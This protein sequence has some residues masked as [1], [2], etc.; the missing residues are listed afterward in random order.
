MEAGS[1]TAGQERGARDTAPKRGCANSNLGGTAEYIIRPNVGWVFFFYQTTKQEEAMI[2]SVKGQ[3]KEFEPGVSALDVFK[4]LDKEARK[5]AIAARLD[6]EFLELMAPITKGGE[7][8]PVGFEDSEARHLL[9]HTASH[10]MASAVKKLF[11]KAKLAIGPSIEH[12]FYYD[13]DVE[14]P[15]QPEDLQKIEKEMARII[16]KN[17]REERF[18]LPRAEAIKLMEEMDEPYK[19]EL[20]NDLPDETELSFYRQGDFVDLCAGP[21]LPST[22]KVKAFKLTSLAGAYWRGNEKNKMLQ[23]IY[24][25]AFYDREEME[26][27]LAR[28]EEAKK[29]DHRKLGRE[30]D[31]FEFMEEGPG[32]PFYYAKGMVLKNLL[33]DYWRQVHKKA[34]YEEI[35]TPLILSRELWEESGHWENYR[36]NMYTL[37]IDEQDF[38]IKP[39]NCPGGILAY[40]RR[41]WSYRD[42]PVR[43]GELG[44]VHRHEKSGALHGMMRVRA[45][46]QDDAHLYMTPEQIKDEIIGV[47]K[48]ED[49]VYRDFG[50]QYKV[51]LST[52]PENSIGSD[53]MWELSTKALKDALDDLAVP[54]VINEGDGAFYGPKI[55]FHLEDSLGRSWQCGT[56]QLD[57]NLPER[58]E[59]EYTGP[60]GAKHRPVMIHRTVL[61]S[62]ERFIG[63]LTEHFGGAF[64]L[65][66]SPIQARI[67]TITDRADDAARALKDKMEAAGLRVEMDLRNEK[68]GFK[69]REAQIMKTPYMLV[70]GDREAEEGTVSL[71]TRQG[72]TVNGL[73]HDELIA[74]LKKEADS[75]ALEQ[76]WQAAPKA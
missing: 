65:W 69:V 61:G 34:G 71:R 21:H 42:F 36:E 73:K 7:L 16:K 38:A 20:I 17:E 57:M 2:I 1:T 72:L 63:I 18:V 37:K 53:E 66:L 59:M 50:F 58:F 45:F 40:K 13:F 46:T 49:Q 33:I 10:V 47:Y 5:D 26:A 35:S 31:L 27:Y 23:R 55:D 12:G 64:P 48:L 32:F 60:D 8:V 4:E 6:G 51:E 41:L 14:E 52:R 67:M 11:P 56:L 43:V 22:G 39:M 25:T 76:S 44:L 62:L 68:I 30:L 74:T 3:E 28:I 9:R 75:R 29:R 15:F 70:I 19:V 54:Y 24:G